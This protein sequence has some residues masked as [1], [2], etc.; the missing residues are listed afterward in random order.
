[1]KIKKLGI[2]HQ[3]AYIAVWPANGHTVDQGLIAVGVKGGM[4]RFRTRKDTFSGKESTA[5]V[6]F[7]YQQ[8]EQDN[9]HGVTAPYAGGVQ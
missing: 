2:F 5:C 1:M 4:D 7:P 6:L 9:G 8:Q 3:K